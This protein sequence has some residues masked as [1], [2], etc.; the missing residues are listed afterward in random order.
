MHKFE[1][2]K[3]TTQVWDE[4]AQQWRDVSSYIDVLAPE[5]QLKAEVENEVDFIMSCTDDELKEYLEF[6]SLVQN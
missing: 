6:S 1:K 4:S 3:V 2:R 5:A